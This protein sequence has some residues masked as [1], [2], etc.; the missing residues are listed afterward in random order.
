MAALHASHPSCDHPPLPLDLDSLV[1]SIDL[2]EIDH[3]RLRRLLFD[4]ASG[5]VEWRRG[6]EHVLLHIRYCECLCD[7]DKL[8][9]LQDRHTY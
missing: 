6:D 4:V 9:I 5:V 8:G 1:N 2:P 3:E 7:L